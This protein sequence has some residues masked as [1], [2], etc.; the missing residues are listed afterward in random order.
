MSETRLPGRRATLKFKFG[1]SFYEWQRTPDRWLLMQSHRIAAVLLPD[2][3]YPSMF[4]IKLPDGSISV[5]VNLTRAK[6]AAL[7]LADA[8]LDGRKRGFQAP[9]IAPSMEAARSDR[10]TT[11]TH[12]RRSS[13]QGRDT[14]GLDVGRDRDGPKANGVQ[15]ELA[16]TNPRNEIC[17]ISIVPLID[18]GESG[19]A[20]GPR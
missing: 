8:M 15:S 2:P 18:D 4:R 3:H 7:S 10:A 14:V 16:R 13:A 20:E 17:A 12:G 1:R 5:M 9:G 11:R 19:E 6:D